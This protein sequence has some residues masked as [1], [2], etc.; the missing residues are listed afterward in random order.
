MKAIFAICVAAIP[1]LL[2]FLCNKSLLNYFSKVYKKTLVNPITV[3]QQIVGFL[4]YSPIIIGMINDD[5]FVNP[6]IFAGIP[7]LFTII[8]LFSNVKF[9]NPIRIVALTI[10]QIVFGFMFICRLFVWIF[11][12]TWS[13]LMSVL[14]G[15]GPTVEYNPF[16]KTVT[17]NSGEVYQVK[18]RFFFTPDSYSDGVLTNLNKYTAD[19]DASR[20]AYERGQL[21]NELEEIEQKKQHAMIYGYDISNYE[22][23]ESKI[24][25]ELRELK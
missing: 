17:S 7:V 6:F 8:L 23:R 24:K 2:Y 20:I 21:E 9:K 16:A 14:Y 4:F 1:F 15:R 12:M 22:D 11:A 5:L 19:M 10:A 3:F 13:I 25:S 18:N